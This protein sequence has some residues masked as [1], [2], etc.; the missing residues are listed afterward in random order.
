MKFSTTNIE[1]KLFM[2]T[3]S[4]LLIVGLASLIETKSIKVEKRTD[5]KTYT[6]HELLTKNNMMKQSIQQVI[7]VGKKLS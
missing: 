4:G 3:A 1:N 6:S 7:I 5:Y 2:L